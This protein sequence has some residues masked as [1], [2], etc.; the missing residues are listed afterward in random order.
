MFC[1]MSLPNKRGVFK[2]PPELTVLCASVLKKGEKKHL[3]L[4]KVR[5]FPG[6]IC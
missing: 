1:G 3:L 4:V 2:A 5:A 6:V